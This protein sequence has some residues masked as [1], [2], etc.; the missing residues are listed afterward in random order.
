MANELQTKLD[1]ILLDKNT[2]LKPENLKSGVTLLGVNGTLVQENVLTKNEYHVAS[3]TALQ[4]LGKPT[5]SLYPRY[6]STAITEEDKANLQTAYGCSRCD[7]TEEALAQ[8]N[9]T[10]DGKTLSE[11]IA[12][13]PYITLLYEYQSSWSSEKNVY[14]S[15]AP[16]KFSGLADG[17]RLDIERT[18]DNTTMGGDGWQYIGDTRE[19]TG[20]GIAEI[21]S[22]QISTPLTT[23]SMISS[24]MSLPSS[25]S[26]VGKIMIFANYELNVD[27]LEA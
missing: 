5:V 13:Y 26:Y 25:G 14:F 16:L 19:E 24:T 2:N 4:I 6:I 21:G 3:E 20:D 10:S 23:Y 15:K 7:F 17:T 27:L 9:I 1:A 11:V 22:N 12:E 18:E 8:D